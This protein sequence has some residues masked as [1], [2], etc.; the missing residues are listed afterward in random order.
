MR[1][2]ILGLSITVFVI[3]ISRA[4]EVKSNLRF[5]EVTGSAETSVEPDE[6]ILF[7]I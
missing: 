6:I 3:G 5:I 4:Q 7:L 2:I 1:K